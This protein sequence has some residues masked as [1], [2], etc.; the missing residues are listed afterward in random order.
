VIVESKKVKH[1]LLPTEGRNPL[2]LEIKSIQKYTIE[3]S[4]FSLYPVPF[5]NT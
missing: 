3:I 5:N 1:K 4:D 2:Y